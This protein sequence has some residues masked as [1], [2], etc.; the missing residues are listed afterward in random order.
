MQR[1]AIGRAAIRVSRNLPSAAGRQ[2]SAGRTADITSASHTSLPPIAG[3]TGAPHRFERLPL[4]RDD[5]SSN[6]HPALAYC[7]SMIFFRRPVST[8]RDHAVAKDIRYR[9][10]ENIV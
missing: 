7:W 2:S 1:N 8:L 3:E 10:I 9:A 6:R 4:K 5:F